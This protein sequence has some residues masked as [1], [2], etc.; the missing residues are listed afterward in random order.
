[1]NI[2]IK[3]VNNFIKKYI[4]DWDPEE[5]KRM[6][7]KFPYDYFPAPEQTKIKKKKTK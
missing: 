4:V 7:D 1:M 5:K 2:I 3:Y 6:Q